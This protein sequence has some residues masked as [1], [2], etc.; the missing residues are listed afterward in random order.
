MINFAQNKFIKWLLYFCLICAFFALNL[1]LL[2]V[3]IYSLQ[4]SSQHVESALA[5]ILV[6][7]II[8]LVIWLFGKLKF[9]NNQLSKSKKIALFIVIIFSLYWI[10]ALF[11]SYTCVM[12]N[13]GQFPWV[14]KW[15][16]QLYY[17]GWFKL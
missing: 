9:T 13:E 2:F 11:F 5:F 6:I 4:K 3:T 15:A 17:S 14:I 7:L 8:G 12:C 1:I 16:E 10:L